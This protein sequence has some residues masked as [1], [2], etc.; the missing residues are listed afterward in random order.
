MVLRPFRCWI[1]MWIALAEFCEKRGEG[2]GDERD[3]REG[4]WG[5]SRMMDA[6]RLYCRSRVEGTEG[7]RR[8]KDVSKCYSTLLIRTIAPPLFEP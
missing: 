2:H 8:S 5:L 7:E 1:R 4:S 6:Y 3:S